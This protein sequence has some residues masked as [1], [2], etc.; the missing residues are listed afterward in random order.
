MGLRST[1][2]FNGKLSLQYY[3]VNGLNQTEDFNGFKSNALL[4]TVTP[5]K[6][7][8][9]NLNYYFGVEGRDLVPAYNPGAPLLAT[10]PDFPPRAYSP[11]RMAAN[12]F[13]IRM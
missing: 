4:F 11:V 7:V 9:W 5:T 3:L 10:L 13:S 12:T 8:S 1:Y 2:K 6:N